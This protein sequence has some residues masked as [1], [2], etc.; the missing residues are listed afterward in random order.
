MPALHTVDIGSK[1]RPYDGCCAFSVRVDSPRGLAVRPENLS[2]PSPLERPWN[3]TGLEPLHREAV[4]FIGR[5]SHGWR[6]AR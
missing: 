6:A 1:R 3:K 4:G 5:Q 2:L